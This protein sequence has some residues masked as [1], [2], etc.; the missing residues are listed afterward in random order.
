MTRE[1][2]TFQVRKDLFAR[3]LPQNLVHEIVRG[4]LFIARRNSARAPAVARA[5]PIDFIRCQCI[6]TTRAV[7]G[8]KARC[9]DDRVVEGAGKKRCGQRSAKIVICIASLAV[10]YD[11][12]PRD[13]IVLLIE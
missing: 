8:R 12:R 9:D 5:T 3:Q 4:Q 11:Q 13:T 6:A 2:D 10:N 7:V 1:H